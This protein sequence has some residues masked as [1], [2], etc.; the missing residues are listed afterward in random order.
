MK[1]ILSA[2]LMSGILLSGCGSEKIGNTKEIL[3]VS[4][5]PTK[6]F[7]EE[8]NKHFK[9]HWE[10]ELNRGK[11]TINQ[12]HGASANQADAVIDG[13]LKADVVT[14][15]IPY[16]VTKIK[17]AGLIRSGWRKEFPDNASPH[18][19]TIV[20]LVRAGNPKNIK[21]WDDLIRDDVKIVTPNPKTS[22]GARWNYLTA[23]EYGRR[24]LGDDK[25]QI[26][27]FMRKIFKNIVSM[28]AGVRESREKFRNGLGD[29]LIAWESEALRYKEEYPA[30]CDVIVPSI[31]IV[32]EL[33][34]AIVDKIS[35]EHN[36]REVSMEYLEYLYSDEGQELAAKNFYRPRNKEILLKY[37][38]QFKP[39]G[40]FT[41][42]DAF[43]GW[44]KS[45]NEHFAEGATFDQVRNK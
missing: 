30:E 11:V 37:R 24:N 41:I 14:L 25:N 15:T 8:Y 27:K 21:D 5:E 32:A 39:I 42:D 1:K 40:L 4:S 9:K 26:L 44:T 43:G 12:S 3:N 16:D 36:T 35:D 23:W 34:V 18:F 2:I 6:E 10:Q 31:S 19:S 29:V 28:D 17:N 38:R 13:K 22:G 20:F 45:Y 7:Y 33:P